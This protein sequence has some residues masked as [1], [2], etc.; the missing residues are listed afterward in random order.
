MCFAPYLLSSKHFICKVRHGSLLRS[1][2]T[3]PSLTGS[4]SAEEVGNVNAI[5]LLSLPPRPDA[6]PESLPLPFSVTSSQ[7]AAGSY[8][9]TSTEN[10]TSSSASS[11]SSGSGSSNIHNASTIAVTA[12]TTT[13]N[14]TMKT[15]GSSTALSTSTTAPSKEGTNRPRFLVLDFTHVASIDATAVHSCFAP[16]GRLS[17]TLEVTN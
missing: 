4:S 10:S 9:A 12:V 11:S 5:P 14:M 17:Q 16:V 1:P 3:R 13:T 7:H 2:K 15:S 8:G 6:L